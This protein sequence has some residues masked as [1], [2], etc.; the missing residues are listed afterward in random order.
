FLEHRRPIDLF[1]QREGFVAHPLLGPLAIVDVRSARIPP[2]DP[3]LLVAERVVADQEPA[4]LAIVASYAPFDL[5]WHPTGQ[6]VGALV[7]QSGPV[8][9]VEQARVALGIR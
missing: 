7:P 1:P 8:L 2:D 6:P 4:V 9:G 5:K 3:S